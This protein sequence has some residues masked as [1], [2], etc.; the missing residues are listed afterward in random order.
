MHIIR[1]AIKPFVLAKGID[2]HKM[3]KECVFHEKKKNGTHTL[4]YA[5]G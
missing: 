1:C 4:F 2:K 5:A 3:K